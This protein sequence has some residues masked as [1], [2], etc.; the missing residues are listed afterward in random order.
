MPAINPYTPP[1]DEAP[2]PNR[3]EGEDAIEI[4]G[5]WSRLFAAVADMIGAAI[6]LY[7]V[8]WVVGAASPWFL[9]GDRGEAALVLIGVS[10]WQS[11][12]AV[13]VTW[14]GQSFGKLLLSTHILLADGRAAGFQ[15]GFLLRNGPVAALLLT[16]PALRLAG[17]DKGAGNAL[18]WLALLMLALDALWIFAAGRRCLH[19]RIAG[20]CVAVLRPDRGPGPRPRG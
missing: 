16:P 10:A 2:V 18:E 17:G 13:L 3:D 8:V 5:Y 14:R 6:V 15:R 1:K 12:Q 11:L 9:K 4:A 7:G 19:D 20:T